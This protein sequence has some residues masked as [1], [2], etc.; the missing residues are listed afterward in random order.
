MRRLLK[1]VS[2]SPHLC[3]ICFLRVGH[4]LADSDMLG[5]YCK[6]QLLQLARMRYG[7][8]TRVLRR[9]ERL[10]Q[11]MVGSEQQVR[12]QP[13]CRQVYRNLLRVWHRRRCIGRPS[14][15]HLMDLLFDR[16]E[17]IGSRPAMGQ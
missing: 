4:E 14:N 16:G 15:A 9:G 6:A 3:T 17:F 2:D 8:L 5:A 10:A 12:Q 11:A 7:T 13:G 1:L